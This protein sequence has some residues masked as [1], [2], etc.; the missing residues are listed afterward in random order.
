MDSVVPLSSFLVYLTCELPLGYPF[1][2]TLTPEFILIMKEKHRKELV[3]RQAAFL[4]I[5]KQYLPTHPW[6]AYLTALKHE[7]FLTFVPIETTP[8]INVSD[9]KEFSNCQQE[10]LKLRNES[11]KMTEDPIAFF[12]ERLIQLQRE[13]PKIDDLEKALN[14]A[15]SAGFTALLPLAETPPE[16]PK[17]IGTDL[18][19]ALGFDG[20]RKKAQAEIKR[21]HH[22][23]SYLQL[24]LKTLSKMS[25]LSLETRTHGLEDVQGCLNT[26]KELRAER[27]FLIANYITPFIAPG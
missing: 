18:A 23:D 9:Q 20:A 15:L 17:G 13:A 2:P 19:G 4:E 8:F 12:S 25:S 7:A 11:R 22:Q 10:W 1:E 16:M 27:D 21:W 6:L 14:G 3:R 5:G 24:S 26:L